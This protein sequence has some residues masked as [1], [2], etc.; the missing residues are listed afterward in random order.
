MKVINLVGNFGI[1][2]SEETSIKPK[3]MVEIGKEPILWHT[4]NTDAAFGPQKFTIA[5]GRKL[6]LTQLTGVHGLL[7]RRISGELTT[8]CQPVA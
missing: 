5:L 2:L 1:R 6:S 7:L 8:C 3:L 4:M